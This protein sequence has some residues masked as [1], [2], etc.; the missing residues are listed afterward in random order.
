MVWMDNISVVLVLYE[1]GEQN[2]KNKKTKTTTFYLYALHDAIY[3]EG[4]NK[5]GLTF[6]GVF[7]PNGRIRLPFKTF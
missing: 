7:A 6:N 5:T 3:I 4:R 2:S 1:N